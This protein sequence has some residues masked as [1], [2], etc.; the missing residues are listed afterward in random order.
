MSRLSHQITPLQEESGSLEFY[1]VSCG[2]VLA[3]AVVAA[4][5]VEF[6]QSGVERVPV[7][8]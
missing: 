4:V 1:Q 7:T 6:V 2:L 3:P 8:K 5:A